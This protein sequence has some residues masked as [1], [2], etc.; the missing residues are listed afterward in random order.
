RIH[1]AY[2]GR[3]ADIGFVSSDRS[4]HKPAK[5]QLSLACT[6]PLR[7]EAYRTSLAVSLRTAIG[8]LG[9]RKTGI[10]D[11]D[12][13]FAFQFDDRPKMEALLGRPE[14]QQSFHALADLGADFILLTNGH[15]TIEI[16]MTFVVPP[17]RGRV[18]EALAT[19]HTLA[20]A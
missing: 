18:S 11:L 5:V 20:S 8:I 16:P 12:R 9:D 4:S 13:R 10:E 6:A 15:L 2:S 17:G 19:M 14:A 3:S 1:G 7:V